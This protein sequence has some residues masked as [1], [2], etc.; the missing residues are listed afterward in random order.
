VEQINDSGGEITM[1]QLLLWNPFILGPCGNLADGQLV[2]RSPPGGAYVLPNPV[3]APTEGVYYTTAQPALPTQI[4]SIEDCGHYY[5]VVAD[6]ICQTV[7]IRH[8]ITLD[9]L[10]EYNAYLTNDCMNL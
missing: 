8:G 10:F 4:G 3:A 6:E 2:C 9:Q 7:A 5:D 1:T